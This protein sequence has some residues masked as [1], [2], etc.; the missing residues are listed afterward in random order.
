MGNRPLG[1]LA[2]LAVNI[3]LRHSYSKTHENEADEYA[4]TLILNTK[5]DPQ[6]VG[7]S[8][9]SLLAD[10]NGRKTAAQ[11]R[12]RMDPIRE[13]FMTHPYLELREEKFRERGRMWWLDNKSEKR[14]V[15]R[16]NLRNRVSLK[17]AEFAEE[18]KGGSQNP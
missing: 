14:Y 15:G 5:Y 7:N 13:Y 17:K 11:T 18:W 4:F 9:A 8:F 10:K 3:L 2:D 16:I 12:Q 6:G 1:E